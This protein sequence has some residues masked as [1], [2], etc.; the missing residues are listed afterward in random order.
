[1]LAMSVLCA[2]SLAWAQETVDW[3]ATVQVNLMT[4]STSTSTTSVVVA[5]AI[6][7]PMFSTT[8]KVTDSISSTTNKVLDPFVVTEQYVKNN[9]AALS[10]DIMLGGGSSIEDLA[11]LCGVPSQDLKPFAKALRTHR[12]Q[13][14][15][16]INSEDLERAQ[17]L[18]FVKEVARAMAADE[19]LRAHLS[20]HVISAL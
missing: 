10:Q 6:L 2:Q 8:T 7:D 11:K 19:Q 13:I 1:M 15:G 20:P 16:Q 14:L 3:D 4:S 12:A 18:G 9:Q 17:V 5:W